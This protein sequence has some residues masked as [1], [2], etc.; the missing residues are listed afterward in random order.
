MIDIISKWDGK[1]VIDGQI[2]D[3]IYD[4]D[5]NGMEQGDVFHIKCVPERRVYEQEEN[6]RG[7]NTVG[8]TDGNIV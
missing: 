6:S 8:Y 7:N 4:T 2:Y 5:L 3:N 1:F